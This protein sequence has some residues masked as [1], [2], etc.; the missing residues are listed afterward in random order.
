MTPGAI[1]VAR[2]GLGEIRTDDLRALARRV[3]RLPTAE[4]IELELGATLG[5]LQVGS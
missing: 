2:Q 3:L 4:E 5:R 1:G